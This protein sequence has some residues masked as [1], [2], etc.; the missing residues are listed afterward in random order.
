MSDKALH[1]PGLW[2]TVLREEVCYATL[3]ADSDSLSILKTDPAIA[4]P[5]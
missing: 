4:G 3:R 1:R 5:Q 2:K